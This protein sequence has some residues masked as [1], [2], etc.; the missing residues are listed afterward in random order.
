MHQT[1]FSN[2]KTF[3]KIKGTF[4]CKFRSKLHCGLFTPF[5]LIQSL[6]AHSKLTLIAINKIKVQNFTY[7]SGFSEFVFFGLVFLLVLYFIHFSCFF[8]IVLC[9]AIYLFPLHQTEMSAS[10]ISFYNQ[11]ASN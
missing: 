1:I 2:D 7:W 5:N 8:F 9:F 6:V 4:Q 10:C 3:L 11:I